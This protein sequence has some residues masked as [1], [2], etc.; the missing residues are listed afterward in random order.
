MNLFSIDVEDAAR[1]IEAHPWIASA[2]V[3][4]QLPETATIQVVERK[5]RILVLFDVPYLVDDA[6]E[7]FKRWAPDDPILTPVLSGIT[8]EQLISDEE[9][10]REITR[11]AISLARRY[12]AAGLES[13]APISEIHQEVDGGFSLTIGEDPFYVRFGKGPFRRKLAR[14][15]TLLKQ[16]KKDGQRPAMIFFDNEV[17]PDR[18]TVKT[19]PPAEPESIAA[20]VDGP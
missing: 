1:R 5:A 12:R 14:L 15:A 4:R 13:I 19:K 18:V 10:V 2:E 17:R 7:I 9:G 6:G 11:T 16:V 20:A 8:R 3:A